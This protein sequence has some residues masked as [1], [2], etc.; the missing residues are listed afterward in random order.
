MKFI[1]YQNSNIFIFHQMCYHFLTVQMASAQTDVIASIE[2]SQGPDTSLVSD[3]IEFTSKH[4]DESGFVAGDKIILPDIKEKPGFSFI[5]A[6]AEQIPPYDERDDDLY[7]DFPSKLC[8]TVHVDS[9]KHDADGEL[10]KKVK[11]WVFKESIR[12]TMKVVNEEVIPATQEGNHVVKIT[13]LVDPWYF[14]D[15]GS[16]DFVGSPFYDEV[17]NKYMNALIKEGVCYM[18]KKVPQTLQTNLRKNL[19]ELASKTAVDYHPNSNDIVRD[20]VHPAL[21]PFIKGV[22]NIKKDNKKP[23]TEQEPK[24]FWGR[25]YENSKFQWLPAPFKITEDGTCLI[26]EYINNLDRSIF[27]E[28][29]ADLQSLFE[30]FLPYFEEVWSYAKAMEFWHGEDFGFPDI[31][32]IPAIEKA[33]VSFNGQELQVITKIVEYTL[34]PGQA[35]EGVWHAEGMSHENIV[36]TG[37]N[38]LLFQFKSI[39]CLYC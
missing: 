32:V 36:M 18:K 8:V 38:K 14:N 6:I 37:K 24:D 39:V 1:I 16:I 9:S 3:V 10:K 15:D 2:K 21:Y 5:E 31:D 12:D 27:P 7:E 4:E 19:D 33:P 13:V 17:W 22:S 30:I 23:P 28:L 29:Y 35:Y 34:Q 25:K 20:L 26:Q 11:N